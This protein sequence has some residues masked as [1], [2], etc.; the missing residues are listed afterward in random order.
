MQVTGYV[1]ENKTEEAV[2]SLQDILPILLILLFVPL[3]IYGK[4]WEASLPVW[5]PYLIFGGIGTFFVIS[6]VLQPA[7]RYKNLL[8][9]FFAFTLL[10]W[11]YRKKKVIEG[12]R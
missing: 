10:Y 1:S 2:E 9:A 5:V 8:F 6:A 4:K 7:L 12:Q 11:T 3:A